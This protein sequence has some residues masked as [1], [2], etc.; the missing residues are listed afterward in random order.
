[1]TPQQT[2]EL[3]GAISNRV[4]G[5]RHESIGWDNGTAPVTLQIGFVN[6]IV[7]HDGIVVMDAPA[8]IM[9]VI[10]KWVAEQEMVE[11]SPG[12]GGL[13]IR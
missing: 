2:A 6:K 4:A 13:L 11:A 12:Y 5:E 8:A 1:M 10:M 3:L 7:I 9:D